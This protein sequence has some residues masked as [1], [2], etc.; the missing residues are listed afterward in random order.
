MTAVCPLHLT[1][2]SPAKLK[3]TIDNQFN[4]GGSAPAFAVRAFVKFAGNGSNSANCTLNAN[5]NVATVFK[6]SSGNFT[7]TFDTAM[8][9]EHYCITYAMQFGT[10]ARD[11]AGG[12]MD[13]YAQ[14]ASAF[15]FTTADA[16]S[17]SYQNYIANFITVVR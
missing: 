9:D 15:S 2:V 4:I 10:S 17:N 7:V 13:V 6:N 1:R 14:S 5:G 3:S 8:P 12:V 16:S 11:D